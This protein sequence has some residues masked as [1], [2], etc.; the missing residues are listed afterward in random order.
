[1][2]AVSESIRTQPVRAASPPSRTAFRH[3]P[4]EVPQGERGGRHGQGDGVRHRL[5][6]IG[7]PQLLDRARRVD[8]HGALRAEALE[9]V[10]LVQERGV[11]DDQGVGPHDGLAHPDGPVVDTAER[12]HRRTRALRAETRERL[13]VTALQKRRHRQQLGS[14]DGTLPAAAVDAYLEHDALLPEP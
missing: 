10:H 7:E 1:M 6:E 11:L 12:H 9:D 14:C 5:G 3:R 8:Q 13:R 2:A 4:P